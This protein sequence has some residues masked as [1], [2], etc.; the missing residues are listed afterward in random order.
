[1]SS[2]MFH[3]LFTFLAVSLKFLL[4]KVLV[5]SNLDLLFFKI[6][7]LFTDYYKSCTTISS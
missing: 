4:L 6:S 2:D 7:S 1:M 5:N 3:I